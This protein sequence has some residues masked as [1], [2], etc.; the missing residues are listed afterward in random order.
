MVYDDNLDYVYTIVENNRKA[1]YVLE[2]QDKNDK[3][4]I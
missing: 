3:R 1:K 4:G 2:R